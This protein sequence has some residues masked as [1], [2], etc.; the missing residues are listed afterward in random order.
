MKEN[1]MRMPNMKRC[2]IILLALFSLM[3]IAVGSSVYFLNVNDY[4]GWISQQIKRSTGYDVRFEGFESNWLTDRSISLSGLSL[5]QQQQ[6]VLHINRL[7]L[8]VDKLDLWQRQL[9]IASIKIN[10]VELE[11]KKFL[12]SSGS[13]KASRQVSNSVSTQITA[14]Q[15]VSW[16][17][18][19]IAKFEVTGLNVSLHSETNSLNLKEMDLSFNDLLL[20]DRSQLQQIP[21]SV[22]LAAEIS[23]LNVS[24]SKHNLTLRNL[25]LSVSAFL[26]ARQGRL[27]VEAD[28]VLVE[29]EKQ[30]VLQLESLA[31]Q[32][33]LQKNKLLL[34]PF[35]VNAF[36]GSLALQAEADLTIK[37]LPEP[38]IKVSKITLVS[39]LAE[40]MQLTASEFLL[41]NSS[42]NLQPDSP[43]SLSSNNA[44]LPIE[45]L[46]IK[47]AQLKNISV[48]SE[49]EKL[50]LTLK[51]MD[52][53]VHDLYVI[54]GHQWLDSIQ[55]TQQAG[56]FS[57]AFE[58]LQWQAL[59]I[60]QFNT[61]G[62]LNEDDQAVHFFK[63]ILVD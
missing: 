60:E 46:L 15:S 25:Q 27:N 7:E 58:N 16:E 37:F 13:H 1:S 48:R 28:E 52:A 29:R 32:L 5:Y 54:K 26:F 20:I 63:K 2:M 50:P 22:D 6:R 43:S 33:A 61:A 51:S 53:Q 41:S 49:T 9:E 18:L 55:D 24:D 30:P 12:L 44:S 34:K 17:R 8:K 62:S 38:A 45:T 23:F 35:F 56:L 21:Q 14:L 36:S 59:Q 57:L 31:L 19:H 3:V 40:N 10:G 47:N 4:A 39:L 11:A 42:P